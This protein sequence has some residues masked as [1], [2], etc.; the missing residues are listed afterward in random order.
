MAEKPETSLADQCCGNCFFGSRIE[1]QH[2][3]TMQQ[4]PVRQVNCERN[5]QSILKQVGQWCGEWKQDVAPAAEPK[6]E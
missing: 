1:R 6:A 2:P 3:D 5:P 4:L